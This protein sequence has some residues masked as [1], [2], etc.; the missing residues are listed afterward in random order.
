[1]ANVLRYSKESEGIDEK[2][3]QDCYMA[4]LYCYDGK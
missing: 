4:T 1:M 3:Y 2:G